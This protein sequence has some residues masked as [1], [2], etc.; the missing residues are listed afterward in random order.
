MVDLSIVFSM[1]TRPGISQEAHHRC[2]PPVPPRHS[3]GL[4]AEAED[5]RSHGVLQQG[6][7]KPDD[8]E[9]D[10]E[11]ST[12]F[13][14]GWAVAKSHQLIAVKTSHIILFGF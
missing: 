6:I 2:H 9:E 8:R 12:G 5:H 7:A 3:L 10:L 1:S 13:S 11:G 4:V 14:C